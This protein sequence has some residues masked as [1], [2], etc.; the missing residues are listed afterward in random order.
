MYKLKFSYL[1]RDELRSVIKYIRQD[2]KNPIAA[3][4]LKNEAKEKT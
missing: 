3:E 1:Y 4:R 2:L